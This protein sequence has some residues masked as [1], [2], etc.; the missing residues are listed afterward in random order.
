[1]EFGKE[2]NMAYSFFLKKLITENYEFIFFEELS[3]SHNQIIL[4]HDIDFDCELAY[5]TAV[6]ESS[7]NVKATYFFLIASES[8][9]IFSSSNYTYI[10]KIVSLGHR[11]SIHFDPLLYD[12]YEKG[13]K[14]E[15]KIFEE[16]FEQQVKTI[17]LHRPNIFFQESNTPIDNIEH[18]YQFKYF[19]DIK[20]FADSTGIWRFGNPL[21]SLEFKENKTL[22]ILTHP[23]WWITEGSS[24]KEKIKSNY[25][26]KVEDLKTHYSNNCKPFSEIVYEL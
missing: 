12:D 16:L 2:I 10:S 17:S 5:Q 11:V 14:K 21:D 22:H 3:Q 15:V 9:N 6:I 23:I 20:Y 19:K 24:N 1:M 13:L 8:Y 18:S 4:R 26:K 7:L 25:F